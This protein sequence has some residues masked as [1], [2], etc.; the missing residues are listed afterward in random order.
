M[1]QQRYVVLSFVIAAILTG[2][3]VQSALVSGFSQFNVSDDRLF[4]LVSTSSLIALVSG[5]GA[6]VAMIRNP[7]WVKF[8]DEVI[9]E[10]AKVTWPT[11]DETVRATTTVIFTTIF[12]AAL[13][14]FYD[15]IWKNVADVFLF[16]EG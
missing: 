6:F 4:G 9:I 10:L 7:E 13:L 14:G 3:A 5:A 8:T 15:L 1:V 2:M 16:T 12:V 11:R